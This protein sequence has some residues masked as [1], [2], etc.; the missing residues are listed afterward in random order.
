MSRRPFLNAANYNEN[1]RFANA[2]K[3]AGMSYQEQKAFSRS[4][5]TLPDEEKLHMDTDEIVSLA[6]EWLSDNRGKFRR[7]YQN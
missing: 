7:E 4:F 2:C 6:Q 1:G 5:H 3:L